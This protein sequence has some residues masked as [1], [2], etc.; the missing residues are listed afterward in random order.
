MKLHPFQEI[1]V[2][3]IVD[4]VIH[5]DNIL[6]S[7]P[8]GCHAK[9]T[10]ILMSDGRTKMV[11]DVSVGDRLMGQ[12][13][14]VNVLQ[15]H[16]GRQEMARIVPSKGDS[17]IVNMDHYLALRILDYRN[18]N[19]DCSKIE[20]VCV[21][22][23]I[24]W[25]KH[26][27][28]QLSR[29]VRCSVAHFEKETPESELPLDPYFL[30][31]YLGDGTSSNG[32]VGICTADDE[33]KDVVYEIADEHKIGIRIAAKEDNK[34][35]DYYFTVGMLGGHTPN[36]ISEKLKQLGLYGLLGGDKF[37]PHQYKTASQEVRLKILAG[38]IDTDGSLADCKT[39]WDYIT[40]S[41]KL[42]FDI[43]LVARSLGL[44]AYPHPVKKSDQNGTV[45]TYW[46]FQLSG[47]VARNIPVR[48]PRKKP[49]VRNH[50]RSVLNIPFSVETL[51]EDD[52]YGFTVDGNNRYLLA[53]L[54][55]T[56]NSGKSLIEV[57]AM[58][59]LEQRGFSTGL[60]SSR[61]EILSGIRDKAVAIGTDLTGKL[62]TPQ[63]FWNAIEN[64]R[65]KMPRVLVV[66]ESHHSIARTWERLVLS[67]GIV[68]VGLTATPM[69]GV[70]SENPP[71]KALFRR[72]YEAITIAEAIRLGLIANFYIIKN[73]LNTLGEAQLSTDR[74]QNEAAQTQIMSN[75]GK[76][77]DAILGL[78]VGRPTVFITPTTT[79]AIKV[80]DYFGMRGI[81]IREILSNTPQ[82]ERQT[83]LRELSKNQ[84]WVSAVN[85]MTEGVDVPEV[86]R[87]VN[88]RPSVSP[89]PY[90]QGLGRGL[91]LIYPKG[92]STPDYS[93]KSVCEFVDFTSNMTRFKDKLEFIMGLKFIEGEHVFYPDLNYSVSAENSMTVVPEFINFKFTQVAPYDIH[94]D[95]RG[96]KIA[97]KVG[98]TPNNT[99]G[100]RLFRHGESKVYT[101]K[102]VMWKESLSP[103]T[104]KNYIL[105]VSKDNNQVLDLAAK[106]SRGFKQITGSYITLSELLVF[107][108][109]RQLASVKNSNLIPTDSE[110]K[111]AKKFLS[112]IPHPII[113]DARLKHN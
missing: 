51:P 48:I 50:G 16:R 10:P 43:A 47:D 111:V 112:L 96:E 14:P 5:G 72:F 33:V 110:E 75:M 12:F 9:G 44:S 2:Q 74:K 7:S 80:S 25:S 65:A 104:P 108:L 70:E 94:I 1:A 87:V 92:Q 41:K 76:I 20:R 84:T 49:S 53:D 90:V 79:A 42:A 17:F 89:I 40:K 60:I 27:K 95:F 24:T 109:L 103:I 38:L 26:K 100:I 36:P 32:A 21:R 97:A 13:D 68:V 28:E 62:W 106:I 23:W 78:D 73:Y 39:G 11:E 59:E 77:Y 22:D 46:R 66:D 45:G 35:K 81:R 93:M 29:L 57:F 31:V 54:T 88:L 71:W 8:T 56:F 3:K 55:L 86:S 83:I 67:K 113:I 64:K 19:K 37:I 34:A 99:W 6:V 18:I 91:R 58:G 107:T 15:L 101:L 102:G 82:D 4:S 52:Y 105:E 85:I 63:R 30:G 69:R 98:E 61:N